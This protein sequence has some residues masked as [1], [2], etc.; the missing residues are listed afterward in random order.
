MR[1]FSLSE[2]ERIHL[3]ALEKE[4]LP[5]PEEVS[6]KWQGITNALGEY[7]TTLQDADF[8]N[9]YQLGYTDGFLAGKE[10][11]DTY[12]SFR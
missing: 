1:K 4:L 3:E 2:L 9:A 6:E 11:K 8:N 12:D 10:Y 7:I 5:I